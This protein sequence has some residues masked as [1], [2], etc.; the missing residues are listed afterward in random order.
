MESV[1]GVGFW[2]VSWALHGKRLAHLSIIEKQIETYQ[3][4]VILT[5]TH[6]HARV[7]HT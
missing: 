1:Y 3:Y 5:H 6:T 2:S 7:T 4:H